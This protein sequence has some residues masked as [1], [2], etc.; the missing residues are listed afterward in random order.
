M[1][2]SLDR[3]WLVTRLEQADPAEFS[4]LLPEAVTLLEPKVLTRVLLSREASLRENM[5]ASR[6][7]GTVATVTE[8]RRNSLSSY[9]RGLRDGEAL[10]RQ[11]LPAPIRWQANVWDWTES[12]ADA[13]AT[14]VLRGAFACWRILATWRKHWLQ[15]R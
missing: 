3:L 15:R 13:A 10:A 7:L 9:W 12:S 6:S 2:G 11:F 8:R 14:R 4:L 5:E 1:R